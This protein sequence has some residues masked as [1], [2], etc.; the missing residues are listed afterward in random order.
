MRHVTLSLLS[1]C[2]PGCFFLQPDGSLVSFPIVYTLD[3]QTVQGNLLGGLLGGLL[4]LEL[5]LELDLEE[6]T[7]AR[8]TGP[9]QHVYLDELEL[10]ITPT[11]ESGFDRDDFDFLESIE[12]HVESRRPG[13]SL[14]RRR[15]AYRDP[16]PDGARTLS[17]TIENV[18]LIDY[19]NEGAVLTATA[20]GRQPLDDVTFDGHLTLI[21]EVL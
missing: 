16:T 6:E 2:L 11:A 1:L 19:V 18:D 8:N 21:V 5:G 12:I 14:P 15:I 10:T 7:R 17:L 13:S 9:A 3:E 4:G 20:S